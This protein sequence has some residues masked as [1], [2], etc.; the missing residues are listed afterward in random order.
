MLT[1]VFRLSI[2]NNVGLFFYAMG[3]TEKKGKLIRDRI[4]TEL[5][6]T[7]KQ[8]S[9]VEG[10]PWCFLSCRTSKAKRFFK[11]I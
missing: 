5:E 2:C 11:F 4:Y 3:K 6:P 10:L 8:I 7:I 9:S 1:N